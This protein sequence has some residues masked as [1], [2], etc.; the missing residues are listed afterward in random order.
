MR[1]ARH[2]LAYS[3]EFLAMQQRFLR[4]AQLL[5]ARF[6]SS[7][8]CCVEFTQLLLHSGALDHQSGAFSDFFHEGG[9]VAL[10]GTRTA[11]IEINDGLQA[12]V[13]DEGHDENRSRI[14][15]YGIRAE[16]NVITQV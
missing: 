13:A 14:D 3:F 9:I 5:R 6:H 15:R 1:H 7:F 10:P 16:P 8:Q 2:K 4:V 12:A 11:I